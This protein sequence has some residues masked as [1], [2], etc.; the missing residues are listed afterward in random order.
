MTNDIR[1]AV[2]RASRAEFKAQI[3]NFQETLDDLGQKIGKFTSDKNEA[4]RIRNLAVKE[5][6]DVQ[7]KVTELTNKVDAKQNEKQILETQL[8][9]L[10]KTIEETQDSIIKADSTLSTRKTEIKEA[11]EELSKTQLSIKG[12]KVSL[13]ELHDKVKEEHNSLTKI[14]KEQLIKGDYEIYSS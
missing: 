1:S 8:S 2:K 4:V 11:D 6:D 12:E 5:R 9:K 14:Q 10:R 7:A 3:K 13:A